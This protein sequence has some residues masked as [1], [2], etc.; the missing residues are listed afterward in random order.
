MK[1]SQWLTSYYDQRSDLASSTVTT[2]SATVAYLLEYLKD[3][4]ITLITRHETAMW[5]SWLARTKGLSEQ[6]ICSHCKVAKSIFSHAKDQDLLPF[7]PFDKLN[8]SAPICQPSGTQL[9]ESQILTLI[10]SCTGAW[11]RMFALCAYAGLRRNEA[12]RLTWRD[13]GSDRLTVAHEGDE[14]TKKRGRVVKAEPELLAVMH[15]IGRHDLVCA[16][17]TDTFQGNDSNLNRHAAKLIKF[18]GLEPWPKPFQT[19]RQWRATTWRSKYPEHVVDAWM[20]HSL[21]VA[22][23]HYASVP[24]ELYR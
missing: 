22:R 21:T 15:Q 10:D 5:R 24:E 1:L 6:T 23:R 12:L 14:T 8:A 20:G 2:Q 18:A 3:K 19:L 11:R 7:N 4:P 17:L 16:G 9:S 13:V